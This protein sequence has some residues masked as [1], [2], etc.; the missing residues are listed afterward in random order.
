MTKCRFLGNACI[1]LIGSK[2]HIIIDPAYIK[3]PT[4]GIEKMFFTHQHSDHIDLEK[5]TEIKEK[6][7]T[8]KEIEMYGPKIVQ[9]EFDIDLKLV[10]TKSKIKLKNGKVRVYQNDC[11]KAESCVAY[12]ITIDNKYL[13]HTADSAKFSN[14][15]RHMRE[16]CDYCFIACFEDHY[17]DYSK[18]LKRIGAGIVI[19]YHFNEQKTEMAKGLVDYLIKNNIIARYIKIGESFEI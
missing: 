17:S 16:R 19:P 11:W 4:E 8:D 5:L 3:P 14:E 6:F 2:D 1:E 9:D 10:K 7:S 18:F 15:L 12:L 13:L